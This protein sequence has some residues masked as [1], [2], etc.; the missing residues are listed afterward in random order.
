MANSNFNC[1]LK[2][3]VSGST[4][5]AYMEYSRKDGRTYAY[6]DSDLP[7]PTMTIAGTTYYDTNFANRVHN[8]VSV[9]TIRT[10]TFSKSVSSGTYKVT[11]N[12]GSGRRS[13][14]ACTREAYATVNTGVGPSSISLHFESATWNSVT[15]TTT[16]GS[17]G[18]GYNRTNIE[19]IV[20][21]GSATASNWEQTG[22]IVLQ[23]MVTGSQPLTNTDTVSNATATLVFNGGIDL[24][25]CTAYKNAAFA[26]TFNSG[27]AI[28]RVALLDDDNLRY[29]PPYDLT[30]LSKTSESYNAGSVDATLTGVMDTTKNADSATIGYQYRTT[31]GG[32]TSEW[33]DSSSTNTSKTA[34]PTIQLAGLNQNTNYTVEVRQYTIEDQTGSTQYSGITSVS[35]TTGVY[36]PLYGSVNG[37]TKL[38]KK[39]YGPIVEYDYYYWRWV[40][41][42]N[43]I[44]TFDSYEYDQYFLHHYRDQKSLPT[45]TITIKFKQ[46]N[47][48]RI[49][50][51]FTDS[52]QM[53]L[54]GI[55]A[56]MLATMQ[57]M[58]MGTQN[59]ESWISSGTYPSSDLTDQIDMG[60]SDMFESSLKVKKL[61][62]SVNGQTKLIYQG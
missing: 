40:G 41:A 9:G 35:F 34:S 18:S 24:I 58:G 43:I 32:V 51:V 54:E 19:Q 3:S 21:R 56:D 12:C 31:T 33:L 46:P 52:S 10:T 11:W 15:S 17:W 7:T 57:G 37:E 28:G 39:I 13:D 1:T 4:I 6:S 49:E 50:M 30:S 23:H 62:G 16:I 61:Y 45:S 44:T 14:F 25:G 59:V 55:A 42:H 8:G 2:V 48:I 20:C 60:S 22:R 53:V 27:G 47:V 38:L 5:S 36:T 26:S 29:T